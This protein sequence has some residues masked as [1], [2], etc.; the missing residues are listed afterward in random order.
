MQPCDRAWRERGLLQ[1]VLAGDETAWRT[2]YDDA[3]ERLA[4]Y[5]RWRCGGLRDVAD[6]I[7]Q[8]TWL[9]AVRRLRSFDPAQGSF[10]AWLRGIA[11]NLLR[12]QF[13]RDGRRQHRLSALAPGPESAPDAGLEQLEQSERVARALAELPDHYEAVLRAKYLDGLC[14]AD[15]ASERGESEKAVESL[16]TRARAAFRTIYLKTE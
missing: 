5:V 8:E 16:L 7:V 2:L 11:V 14:V 13:R 6:E 4:T 12:N 3:F 15:I 1:A 9:T 10:A